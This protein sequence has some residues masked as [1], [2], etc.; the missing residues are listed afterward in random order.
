MPARSKVA[1]LP[2]EVREELDRRLIAGSFSDYTGLAE[3]LASVGH[4]I[5]RS[6]LHGHGSQLERKIEAVRLATEQATALVESTEGR[7]GDMSLATLMMAQEKLYNLMLASDGGNLK[8]VASAARA[9]AD[10][11]RAQV[12]VAAE[13]RKAVAEAADRAG[14]AAA[15]A[16]VSA[17]T[18]AAIRTAIEGAA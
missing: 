4:V 8:E 10:M 2:P 17:D 15:R 14:E 3:W 11:A 16:G 13:R 12:S 1:Q 9:I 18:M 5:S 6:A 7:P